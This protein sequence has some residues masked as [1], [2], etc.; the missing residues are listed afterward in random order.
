MSIR[1][2]C[3]SCRRGLHIPDD[4]AG[5]RVTC[6]R[7][8]NPVVVPQAEAV[9]AGEAAAG[10]AE[11]AEPSVPDVPDWPWPSRVGLIS[12][13]LGLFSVLTLCLPVIGYAARVLSAVG[14]LLG[15][16]A[17]AAAWM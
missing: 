2:R 13:G 17:L 7:C 12:A 9:A 5:R 10:E 1:V 11:A 3:P 15:L 16:W 8:G 4:L 14:L 6:P